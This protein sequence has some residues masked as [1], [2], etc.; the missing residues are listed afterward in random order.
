MKISSLSITILFLLFSINLSAQ[1]ESDTTEATEKSPSTFTPPT[2]GLGVGLISFYGDLRDYKYGN[3][4]VSNPVYEL[5]VHQPILDYLSLNVYFMF[6]KMRVEERR[7]ERNLNFETTIR[8]SGL[9]FEYN[10]GNFLNPDR[11]FSPF[12]TAGVEIFEFNSKTDLLDSKGNP[13]YYWN[14]GTIRNIAQDDPSA[15]FAVEV[16]RDYSYETDIRQAQFGGKSLYAE[17]GVAIPLGVGF[18]L[19][20][21][22]QINFRLASTIHLTFTDDIDGIDVHSPPSRLAGDRANANNDY[23]LA[24]TVSITYNF[25]KVDSYK[26]GFDKDEVIDFSLYD[27][28]DYDEDG[29]IDFY[30][31]CPNTPPGTEVDTL[32]CPIDT[33]GDGLAD[34]L[35]KEINS[36]GITVNAEGVYLTDEMIYE[37]YLRYS[38]TTG[39]F[40]DVV[41]T[42]FT[43]KSK[44][45]SR[46]RINVGE[47]ARGMEPEGI[48]QLL[49]LP[50]LKTEV[51]DSTVVYS[52][53]SSNNL[54][55][56]VNRKTEISKLGLNPTI[57]ER[58]KNNSYND[59]GQ[60]VNELKPLD[61]NS[62]STIDPNKV[63]FRI[64]LGAFKSK[65]EDSYFKDIDNL[66]VIE[67]DNIYRYYSGAFDTF[68][69]AAKHK[70]KMSFSGFK[71]AFV[72]AFKGG[73]KVPLKSVGVNP[74]QQSPLIGN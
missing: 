43:G 6:G 74:I 28:N 38:D 9:N 20:I 30:D 26:D 16:T 24:S 12:I 66:I 49:N 25:R 40:A 65:P 15:E 69:E 36:P 19:K 34:Y 1:Y 41:S 10:F 2:I 17:R 27:N 45:Q 52:V 32:G 46:F 50:D 58:A 67:T 44:S 23:F 22:D 18:G 48:E 60:R 54:Q 64:Q 14:D 3:P 33:D 72:A 55:D 39:E 5:Y 61:N 7:V 37:S 31:K 59:A 42:N 68:E 29:I 57:E 71:G 70:V 47:Y 53:G 73:K 8:A 35:D 11:N 4:F 51:K 63:I 13:Y 56:V 21:T 62:T